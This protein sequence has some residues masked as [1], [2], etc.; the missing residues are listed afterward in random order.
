MEEQSQALSEFYTKYRPYLLELRKSL[1]FIVILFFVG[2]VFGLFNSQKIFNFILNLYN[3]KDVSIVTTSPYQYIS[4]SFTISF[5]CGILLA[6][7]FAFY[8]LFVFFKPALKP[9]EV[10]I[11][12]KFTPLS[13]FLFIIGFSFGMWIMQQIINF[14]STAWGQ[15]KVN[16][17]WD[18]QNFFAQI[19]FTSFL[20]GIIFQIPILI[21]VLIRLQIIK[22]SELIKKRKYIYVLLL[23]TAILLPPTDLV[24]LIMLTLPLFFL[25]EFGLLLNRH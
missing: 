5:I 19:I 23:I 24:S 8:R 10:N 4:L 17:F 25:F 16:S 2:A 15:V 7:P 13:I 21:S 12:V 9:A 22:R 14:Y 1:F 6:A 18:V 3:F 11:L 20:T